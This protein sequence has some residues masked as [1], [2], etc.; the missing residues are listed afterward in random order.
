MAANPK[1]PLDRLANDA[2]RQNR[3]QFPWGLVAGI[4]VVICL[5]LLGFYFFQ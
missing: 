4:I 5:V 1:N 3:R 2:V